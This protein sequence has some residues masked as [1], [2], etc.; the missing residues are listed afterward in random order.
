MGNAYMKQHLETATKTG[1]LRISFKKLN[2][3]PEE[4]K[5]LESN[6]RTLDMSD[7]KFASL[8]P[9][10]GNFKML[11]HLTISNNRI[12]NLPEEIGMLIKL[13]TFAAHG[14]RI[15]SLPDSIS[16]LSNLKIVDLSGNKLKNF[17]SVFNGLK[18]LNSIDLSKNEITEVT[19]EAC[20][21][22]HVVEI[23]LNQNQ[24]SSITPKLGE[25]PKLRTLRLEE[26]CLQIPVVIPLMRDSTISLLAL[27]GNLFDMKALA[28]ADGYEQYMDRYTAVKKKL[29]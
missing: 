18:K 24:I 12:T 16:A 4:L 5:Q 11:K 1:V 17:P 26:N 7:N 3:V 23:N 28:H 20:K 2:E 6:L 29:Y 27:E 8:P 19:E 13:D 21:D 22:L 9:W 10:L 25:C 14:N 15:A